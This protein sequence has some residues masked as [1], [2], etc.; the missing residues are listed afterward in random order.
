MAEPASRNDQAIAE[1][2]ANG[3]RLTGPLADTP[4]LLLHHTGARSGAPRV[5]PLVYSRHAGGR[6]VVV[7]SNGGAA[8]NP[9]WLHNLRAH[10]VATVEIGT[11]TLPVRATEPVGQDRDQLWAEV[12]ARYPSVSSHQAH[13]ARNIPLVVLLPALP[14]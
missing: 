6:L 10:P 7:A 2:R 13:T 11:D 4:V 14:D 12:I 9:A 8:G 5:T 1:F 3:G